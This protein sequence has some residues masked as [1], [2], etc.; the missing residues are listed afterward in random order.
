[1][2]GVGTVIADN[3]LL[4]CR[5]ENGRN[6]VRIVCDTN[7]RTP[8]DSEIVKTAKD[9]PTI[10]ATCSDN[11]EKISVYENSGC[12]IMQV[13]KSDGH[14][15]LNDLMD[16][17]GEKKIDSILLEGGGELNYSALNA[18]IVNK[19]QAYVAPKIFG[20][21]DAKTPVSGMGVD[22]PDNAYHIER[23]AIKRIGD[24]F[25]IEGWVK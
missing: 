2:V 18:G 25:L 20:G 4:T 5:L 12:R 11:T 7:L 23:T 8:V 15:D 13:K 3:P 16:K 17:L 19:I 1:M 24:D 9:I 22:C 21:Y 6:P 10:I 14:I